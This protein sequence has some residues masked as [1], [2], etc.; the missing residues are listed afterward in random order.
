[1]RYKN[2]YVLTDQRLQILNAM[3][4]ALAMRWLHEVDNILISGLNN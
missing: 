4:N 2:E 1:M 3:F